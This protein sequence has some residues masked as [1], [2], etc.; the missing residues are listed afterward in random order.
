MLETERHLNESLIE[1]DWLRKLEKTASTRIQAT[2]SNLKSAA[3]ARLK[4]AERQV[5]ELTTKLN[6][7][8]SHSCELRTENRELKAE[9]DEARTGVQKAEDTAQAYYDQGFK[10]GADFLKSQLAQECNKYFLQGW[11]LALDQAGVD[12]DS[13]LYNLGRRHQPFKLD[14]S[15]EHKEQATEDLKDPEADE[16]PKDPEVAERSTVHEQIQTDDIQEVEGGSDKEDT[17]NVVS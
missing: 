7:E 9:V 17:V 5:K 8:I 12:D 15:E 6:R 2:K 14:S 4:I 3:E 13:E 16:D 1:N 11:S 10:E